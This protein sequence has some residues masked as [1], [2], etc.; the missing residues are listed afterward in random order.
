[1]HSSTVVALALVAAVGPAFAAPARPAWSRRQAV[2]Q[3]GAISVSEIGEFVKIGNDVLDGADKLKQIITGHE[4]RTEGVPLVARQAPPTSTVS[5]SVPVP[6]ASATSATSVPV[7]LTVDQS[8]AITAS[9][10]GEFVKIGNDVL[11]GAEKLKQIITGHQRRDGAAALL[12]RQ[13]QATTASAASSV[14]T[15]DPLSAAISLGTI[16]KIGGGIDKVLGGFESLF[17]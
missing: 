13:A 10:I 2:D 5:V 12:A 17:G 7:V 11:D 9:E 14:P 8:G 3:S 4:K 15:L 16:A 6:S 1:M